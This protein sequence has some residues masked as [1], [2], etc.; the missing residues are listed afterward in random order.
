M[1]AEILKDDVHLGERSPGAPLTDAVIGQAQARELLASLRPGES[2]YQPE[3]LPPTGFYERYSFDPSIVHWPACRPDL[4]QCV[5]TEDGV[6]L[7]VVDMK[8]SPGVKLSHRIQAT[9]YTL[10]LESLLSEWGVNDRVASE[11]AGIWLAQQPE[12]ELFDLRTLRAPIEQFLEHELQTLLEQP[13]T[14]APWHLYFRCEWCEY[15]DHCRTEM[16]ETNSISRLPYLTTHARRFLEGLDPTVRTIDDFAALLSDP[17][18]RDVIEDC[19]SLRGRAPRLERQ[20]A[21]LREN[22]VEILPGASLAMPRLENVRM[23]LTAQNEPVSGELYAYGLYVQGIKDVLGGEKRVRWLASLSQVH[24]MSSPS[25]SGSSSPI[26]GRSSNQST[27][28][29]GTGNGGIESPCRSTSSTHT[30]GS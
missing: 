1:I 17:G 8:A 10:I 18:R 11:E 6:R 25:L 5:S 26:S 24:P 23:I 7:R 2:I 9:V 16:R 14:A 29:I 28:S 15:F 27:N 4:I 21:A 19:A 3:L 20:L 30:S 12:P 13:A 22:E